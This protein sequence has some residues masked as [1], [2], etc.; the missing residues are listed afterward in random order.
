VRLKGRTAIVTGG[1]HGIGRA[2]AA[3]FAREGAR[4]T[5]ADV[6]QPRGAAAA[7]DITAAGGDCLFIPCDV[8]QPAEVERMVRE[9][10]SAR[11]GVDILV[12]NAALLSGFGSVVDCS[13]EDWNRSI[14]I[15]LTGMFL[16]AKHAVSSMGEGGSIINLASVGAVLPFPDQ[17]PYVTIK[18]GVIQLTRSMAMDLGRR[19]IRVNAIA[20]GAIDTHPVTEEHLRFQ[21][22]RSVLGRKGRPDDVAQAALF[23]CSDDAAFITGVCL[24]VDGGWLLGKFR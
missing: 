2:T 21:I 4:V 16:C 1:A 3:V 22:A 15:G 7:S 24:P 19:G 18:A 14:A 12:N 11:G 5:I 9:T 8:A 13:L 23:L 10:V 17:A 20:P 6:D